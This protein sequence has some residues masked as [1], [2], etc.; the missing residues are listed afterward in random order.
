M[1]LLNTRWLKYSFLCILLVAC[2]ATVSNA[3]HYFLFWWFRPPVPAIQDVT[4]A[5]VTSNFAR[6]RSIAITQ[7]VGITQNISTSLQQDTTTPVTAS[8]EN[9]G[10]TVSFDPI[11]LSSTTTTTNTNGDVIETQTDVVIIIND[12]D[13]R[14]TFFSAIFRTDGVATVEVTETING[15]PGTPQALDPIDLFVYGSIHTHGSSE[16]HLRATV[17]GFFRQFNNGYFNYSFLSAYLNST[18][19][20]PATP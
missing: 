6:L 13:L 2:T 16:Y 7:G 17:R 10:T 12:G 9:G 19:P 5:D 11:V 15:T 1:N 20:I 8:V 18:T 3:F 4:F 14:N